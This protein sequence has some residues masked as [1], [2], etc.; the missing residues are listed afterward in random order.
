MYLYYNVIYAEINRLWKFLF[1]FLTFLRFSTFFRILPHLFYPSMFYAIKSPRARRTPEYVP[2]ITP[3][4]GLLNLVVYSHSGTQPGLCCA[5]PDVLMVYRR[6]SFPVYSA[7]LGAAVA[8]PASQP[9]GCCTRR[10]CLMGRLG[11]EASFT[12]LP[13]YTITLQNGTLGTF[14]TIFHFLL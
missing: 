3:D 8:I 7:V 10:P 11:E 13:V 12:S 2:V 14:R 1:A 5:V 6:F 9:A 4:V